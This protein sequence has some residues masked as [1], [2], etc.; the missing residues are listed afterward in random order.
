VSLVE[1]QIDIPEKMLDSYRGIGLRG[2]L[3]LW[4]IMEKQVRLI[5]T[6]PHVV[7]WLYDKLF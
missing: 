3:W 5:Y 1:L 4:L 7:D 6:F 2:A